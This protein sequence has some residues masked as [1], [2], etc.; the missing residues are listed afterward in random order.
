[1]RLRL[2]SRVF[3]PALG[4]TLLLVPALVALVALGHWQLERAAEKR[5]L[6]TA[7]DAAAA[8]PLGA[9]GSVPRYA[10][11]TLAGHYRPERQFLLDNMT[12]DGAA[13]YR[14]LTPFAV[15]GGPLVLV[16]RGWLAAGPRRSVLPA[17][18]VAG[19]PRTLSGRSDELPRAGIALA[20]H[21]A[22]GWPKVVSYPTHAALE[23]ALGEPLYPGVV[24][25]D[26]ALPDG[27]L[28]DWHPGGFPPE[29]HVGYA[30][31]WFAFAAVLLGG[32]VV[33]SL[34]KRGA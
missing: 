11:V 1:M 2:G 8:V 27:Y 4:A 19:A 15:D 23:R 31:Q 32:Y 10:R 17:I 3:A 25:L 9:P 20:D 33:T 28:R 6:V 14:V 30:L 5:A 7:F 13:G 12:H 22:A 16:D 21:A 18:D 34:G 29:R 26:A 24:L